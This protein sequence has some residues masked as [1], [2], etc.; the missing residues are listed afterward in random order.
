MLTL[1]ISLL[2]TALKVSTPTIPQQPTTSQNRHHSISAAIIAGISVSA[3]FI[4]SAL[5]ITAWRRRKRIRQRNVLESRRA[6]PLVVPRGD[7]R[8]TGPE[9]HVS[10][11][12]PTDVD[13]PAYT[14]IADYN[15][16]NMPPSTP[17][18]QGNLE[19]QAPIN[20]QHGPG[21]YLHKRP[22]GPGV[23]ERE[24]QVEFTHA[25]RKQKDFQRVQV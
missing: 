12:S 6:S 19:E 16:L 22:A 8:V 3:F 15:N 9:E 20:N 18:D 10:F 1:V 23:V 24:G 11:E 5:L 13:P 25:E 14:L 7:V 21:Q 4:S 2:T 17:R